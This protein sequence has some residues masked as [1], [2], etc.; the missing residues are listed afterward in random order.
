M[1]PINSYL[2]V[3]FI[4]T[5]HLYGRM[6]ILHLFVTRTVDTIAI[7]VVNN[8]LLRCG[9]NLIGFFLP[10][11]ALLAVTQPTRPLGQFKPTTAA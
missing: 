3:S 5:D 8:A 7:H 4:P 10:L 9:H 11:W 2:A 1:A 6:I